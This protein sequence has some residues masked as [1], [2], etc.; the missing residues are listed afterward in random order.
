MSE[1]SKRIV[2]VLIAVAVLLGIAIVGGGVLLRGRGS[3]W[4]S[5]RQA[6][7]PGR[8]VPDPTVFKTVR[9]KVKPGLDLERLFTSS[10]AA[11]AR[12][13]KL[14]GDS[15]SACHGTAG[16]GDGPAAASLRPPPRNF[17]SPKGWTRGYT[18]S[19]IYTTLSEG[20]QNTPMPSFD[21]LSPADRFALTH[22]IQSLG[23]FDHHDDQDAEIKQLDA[24][25]HLSRGSHTPNKVEVSIVMKHMAGEYVAPPAVRVPAASNADPGARLCRRAIAD[26]VRAAEVLSQVPDWRTQLEPFARAAMAGAPQNGFQPEVAMLDRDQWQTL[27]DELVKRTP[28]PRHAPVRR[29]ALHAE[30]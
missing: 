26:P 14:F 4:L 12:G 13:K 30:R 1:D 3:H 17:T 24:Q 7:A 23:K 18:V 25:Y 11:V 16:K 5:Y 10:P 9:G 28:L 8:S 20:I 2:A 6:T 22:Y 21:T 19:E 15:C 29:V 27:H